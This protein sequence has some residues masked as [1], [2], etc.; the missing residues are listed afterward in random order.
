M[1]CLT[2]CLGQVHIHRNR[3]TGKKS[4][5]PV[6]SVG[7]HHGNLCRISGCQHFHIGDHNSLLVQNKVLSGH[8]LSAVNGNRL[9]TFLVDTA[10]V[11]RI[12]SRPNRTVIYISIVGN[13][14]CVIAHRLTI[15]Q[16]ARVRRIVACL[17]L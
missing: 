14:C 9:D 4:C 6:C 5:L 1:S 10:H 3:S 2:L 8:G 13:R 15:V 12:K 17:H 16:S 11:I 7:V